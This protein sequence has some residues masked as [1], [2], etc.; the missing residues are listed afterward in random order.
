MFIG[1]NMRLI[2]WQKFLTP[3]EICEIAEYNGFKISPAEIS[4]AYAGDRLSDERIKLFAL[5]VKCPVAKLYHYIPKLN[6]FEFNIYYFIGRVPYSWQKFFGP[7]VPKSDQIWA[8]AEMRKIAKYIAAYHLKLAHKMLASRLDRLS[9]KLGL[10]ISKTAIW[11]TKPYGK[12]R[13]YH[14]KNI[15]ISDT[16]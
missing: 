5:I 9:R 2:A 10:P 8:R 16:M 12:K 1:Y 13:P 6:I 15:A 7:G 14:K 11:K 4:F 3:A